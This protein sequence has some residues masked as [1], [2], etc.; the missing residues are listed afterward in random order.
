[1]DLEALQQLITADPLVDV[2]ACRR[3]LAHIRR[4]RGVLDA[5]E[6]Q[7][8]GRLDQLTAT[9]P[10][11]FP[12]GELAAASKSSLGK[13]S[14]VRDRQAACDQLPELADA[15]A[16]GSTTGERVDAV[17]RATAGLSDGEREKVAEHGASIAAAASNATDRQFR[18]LLEGIVAK[19]RRDDGLDQLAKQRSASGL[20][21]WTGA[22]G[23]WNFTGK[24]DPVRGAELEGRL[25]NAVES[26]FHGSAAARRSGVGGQSGVSGVA[27]GVSGVA[28]GVGTAGD[29]DGTMSGFA[30]DDAP[31]DPVLRQQH[32]SV[33]AVLSLVA[34]TASAG[35]APDVTVI[36]DERTLV[37]GGRHDQSVLDAGL[38]RFGL[39]VETVRRWACVGSVTPV[40]VGADGVRLFLG[41]ETRLANREQRRALRVLYRTCALCDVPFEHTQIHHVSWFGRHGGATDIGNLLPLCNRHHHLVHEGGWQLE[42][43]PD[44]RLTVTMPDGRVLSHGPPRARAA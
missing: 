44:R 22:D 40:V 16:E 4:G 39:P 43:H 11:V 18:E 9:Q 5:R 33:L 34:G 28:G 41:R 37:E 12:E 14:K 42:L 6:V 26:L 21:W 15:L 24:L 1:M 2:A 29:L 35:G 31:T 38:G 10:S 17:A 25:R 23:M 30:A 27:G 32:L 36:I 3:E 13:A 20:R 7:V 8:L 19:A